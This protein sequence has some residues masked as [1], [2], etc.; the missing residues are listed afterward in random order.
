M[1]LQ[2]PKLYSL[3][4]L[5]TLLVGG[6]YALF[7]IIG[8]QWELYF[9]VMVMLTTG[10]PHGAT[11]HIVYQFE[12][13][14][15]G[16][17][18][19]WM[20][21]FGTYLGAMILYSIC[22]YFFPLVSLGIFLLISAFHFGQSQLLFM[23][24]K[25][26]H[27]MKVILYISWGMMILLG[28][29]GFHIEESMIILASLFEGMNIE[30]SHEMITRATVATGMVWFASMMVSLITEKISGIAFFFELMNVAVLLAV[31]SFTSLLL[32]FALYFGL[33]HSLASIS[34][35]IQIIK[36]EDINFNW[37]QFVKSALPF[38][39]ISFA[40]IAI[41]LLIGQWLHA[42]VSPYLLFFI[43]I[44]TLT[45]PHMVFMQRLYAKGNQSS[46]QSPTV[47]VG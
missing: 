15:Q 36:Q 28:I 11:D 24:W 12:H 13:K 19:S 40:G 14:K 26:L 37:K 41:L 31:S 1:N 5:I 3:S 23:D 34:H 21:F 2:S 47:E 39:L 30:I 27:P 38:S 33:W 45:L 25:E 4:L 35:E 9:F 43:A 17:K 42:I 44:S 10:I 18:P 16:L 8:Q 20:T 7:P 22:W 6:A 32:S 46:K 29:I